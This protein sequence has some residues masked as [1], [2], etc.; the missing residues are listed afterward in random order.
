MKNANNLIKDRGG[1]WIRLRHMLSKQKCLENLSLDGEWIKCSK[2]GNKI[3]Y[4]YWM[5]GAYRCMV[6]PQY[7]DFTE[8]VERFVGKTTYGKSEAP[9]ES[10]VMFDDLINEMHEE[11][12]P[13]CDEEI[14]ENQEELING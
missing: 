11:M 13:N 2:C 12:S 10:D 4:V 3:G 9:S 8:D 5:N 6:F 14:E 1:G 7:R